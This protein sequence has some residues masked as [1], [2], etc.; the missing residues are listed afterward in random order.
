MDHI[1]T[2]EE[3]DLNDLVKFARAYGSLGWA[4]QAQLG[5]LIEGDF[6][7]LNPN[8][9]DLI[10]STLSTFHPDIESACD[11]YKRWRENK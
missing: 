4:V 10:L 2:E 8:A 6:K 9:V 3:T 11:E 5:N 7:G 1:F